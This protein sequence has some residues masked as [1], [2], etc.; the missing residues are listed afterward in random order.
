MLAPIWDESADKLAAQL[1]QAKV[2]MGKVP[3]LPVLFCN[4]SSGNFGM[5]SQKIRYFSSG[6]L[7]GL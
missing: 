4:V 5:L 1:P 6:S 7:R 2:V 3:Y